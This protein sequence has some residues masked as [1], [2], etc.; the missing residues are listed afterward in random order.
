MLT[1]RIIP[2]QP[3]FYVDDFIEGQVELY[4]PTQLILND[5]NIVLNISESW[6]TYSNELNRNISETKTQPLI[7]QNLNVKE[8]LNIHT[9]LAALSP[10]KFFFPFRIKSPILLAPSFEFPVKGDKAFIRYILS[11]NII[12]P[13]IK[14]NTSIYIIL[15][16]RQRIEM[17]KQVILTTE[18]NV[19]KWGMFD[20]GKIK[21]KVTSLNGTDNFRFGEDI[22]FNIDIDNT[23]GKMDTTEC[24]IVLKRNVKFMNRF[25]Q[26][27]KNIDDELSSTKVKTELTPGEHKN[28]S[29]VFSLKNI[30][31]KN[32]VIK[33]SGIPYTNISDINYFLASFKTVILECSYSIIFT[34]NFNKLV[35]F[36]E[37]PKII[38]NIIICHQSLEEGKAEMAQILN[39]NRKNT[40]P[41]MQNNI[42]PPPN[43]IPPNM[44]QPPQI[45]HP[46]Q[47]MMHQ[48]NNLNF[49]R[50]VS[51]PI[52]YGNPPQQLNRMMNNN[53][54]NNQDDDLPSMEEVEKSHFNNNTDN[55]TFPSGNTNNN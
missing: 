3:T 9:D 2:K 41:N 11:S 17:N 29:C 13:Y 27:K 34:L 26:I 43:M 45:N 37:G 22:K 15:K 32:F 46:N 44:A 40:M 19:Y 35:K 48:M 6:L 4:S 53:M 33:G 51:A 21:L 5:I 36:N 42:L 7:M 52:N 50:S 30:Q 28:F 14:M 31:N 10:G 38:F 18:N 20:G 47:N 24:K 55:G 54:N 16:R 25:G 12:S 49:Q 23:N 39:L 1:L 8:K